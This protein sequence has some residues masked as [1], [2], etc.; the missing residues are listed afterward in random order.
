MGESFIGYT[1]IGPVKIDPAKRKKAVRVLRK[2]GTWARELQTV[3]VNNEPS[4][5][6]DR[7]ME[8]LWKRARTLGL[9][10]GMLEDITDNHNL[11]D[12]LVKLEVNAAAWLVDLLDLWTHGADD[13]YWRGIDQ[14]RKGWQALTVGQTTWG[15]TPTGVAYELIDMAVQIGILTVLGLSV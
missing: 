10:D 11:L 7:A 8:Q 4:E 1:V 15:D 13:A 14:A 5:A 2:V 9:Y 12:R 6:Y 3:L